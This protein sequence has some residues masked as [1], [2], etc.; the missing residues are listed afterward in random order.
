M[1]FSLQRLISNGFSELLNISEMLI[2]VILQD[3]SNA[4]F[5]TF[6]EESCRNFVESR[7]NFDN[8]IRPK[9]AY[10]FKANGKR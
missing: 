10:D 2:S 7:R 8:K 4:M 1:Q 6:S 5:H 9:L 3:I